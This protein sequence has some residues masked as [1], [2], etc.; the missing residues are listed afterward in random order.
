MAPE[1]L[2][3]R[4]YSEKSDVWAYGVVCWEIL[5]R[6]DPYPNIQGSIQSHRLFDILLLSMNE[7][8]YIQ[9]YGHCQSYNGRIAA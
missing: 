9:S 5:N 7:Y 8:A 1:S 4:I 2:K 3:D 6:S